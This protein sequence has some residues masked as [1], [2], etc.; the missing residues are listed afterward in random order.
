MRLASITTEAMSCREPS[1]DE[2]THSRNAAYLLAS[3]EVLLC[4]AQKS[5]SLLL[6]RQFARRL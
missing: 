4:P 2:V 3:Y 6:R 1:D 5:K